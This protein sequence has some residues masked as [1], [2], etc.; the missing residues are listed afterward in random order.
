M[1]TAE[2]SPAH[3]LLRFELL[4]LY[5]VALLAFCNIAVFY[6]FNIYMKRIGIAAEWRGPLLGMEPLAALFLRPLISPRLHLRNGVT[7]MAGSLVLIIAAL[8]AY[9]FATTVPTLALVRLLHGTGFVALVSGAAAVFVHFIP[10]GK[11]AAA[12][13]VFTIMTQA[14]FAIMPPFM[15]MMLRHTGNEAVAYA[16][17]SLIM[18]P[19][20]ALLYP[21]RKRVE[22]LPEEPDTKLATGLDRIRESLLSRNVRRLLLVNLLLFMAVTTVYFFI[23][24]Y[25]LSIRMDRPGLFFTFYIC[26]MLTVRAFGS[27]FFDRLDKRKGI[28]F[29]LLLLSACMIFLGETKA[30]W[31]VR[32][33]CDLRL[34]S[35][36]RHAAPGLRRISR[37]PAAK[38]RPQYES[39]ALHHRRR[40]RFRSPA[41]RS[42]AGQLAHAKRAVPR[43]S[44]IRRARQHCD[45]GNPVS[46]GIR[47]TKGRAC[48]KL[49]VKS[50][51]C[52]PG[53]RIG[54][55]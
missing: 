2:S 24:D 21:L 5:A 10:P 53:R 7:V 29:A 50:L 35:G 18:L 6:S 42:A 52:A 34:V 19:A 36:R 26:A 12:F 27:P 20:L 46:D 30:Q 51:C 22:R 25:A 14:P 8:L 41:R 37:I 3:S 48:W 38:P 4:V 11:S 54:N 43:G 55:S 44:R 28:T 1:T 15:E 23:K 49:I 32:A 40:I 39:H 9:R 45:V 31:A 13:G 47:L 17:V 16:W 33:G